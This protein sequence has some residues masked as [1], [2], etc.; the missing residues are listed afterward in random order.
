MKTKERRLI[1]K[2]LKDLIWCSGSDDF[3]PTG[4]AYIGWTKGPAKTIKKVLKYLN[5]QPDE[6][7]KE[8]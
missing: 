6:D 8:F 3:G 7:L 1:E 4:M 2:L 5:E